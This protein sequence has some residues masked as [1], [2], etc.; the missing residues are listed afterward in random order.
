[1]IQATNQLQTLVTPLIE[2]AGSCRRGEILPLFLRETTRHGFFP[3]SYSLPPIYLF[4]L[5]G[6]P[7]F[8]VSVEQKKSTPD[9][10]DHPCPCPTVR[11]SSSIWGSRHSCEDSTTWATKG[12]GFTRQWNEQRAGPQIDKKPTHSWLAIV[13]THEWNQWPSC[14][15]CH[16]SWST[17]KKVYFKNLFDWSHGKLLLKNSYLLGK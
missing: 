17:E 2:W 14:H 7:G 1:M 4:L 15:C 10:W 9:E 12:Y 13:L 8:K 3:V 16:P 11:A 5:H 6:K